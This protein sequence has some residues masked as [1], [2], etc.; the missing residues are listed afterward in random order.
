[1]GWSVRLFGIPKHERPRPRRPRKVDP[2]RGATGLRVLPTGD[3]EVKASS[4]DRSQETLHRICG[5]YRRHG[6]EIEMAALLVPA[7][8]A[9]NVKVLIHGATVG[10]LRPDDARRYL[11]SLDNNGHGRQP[12]LVAALITGGRI[13]GDEDSGRFRV[14]LSLP[15][16][17]QLA[18]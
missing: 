15:V 16:S 14:S 3:Y 11:S 10:A 8:D 7:P 18:M 1:M 2:L 12:A 5:G 6:H 13:A 4:E 9:D 17:L